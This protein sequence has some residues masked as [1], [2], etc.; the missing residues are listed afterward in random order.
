MTPPASAKAWAIQLTKMLAQVLGTDRFP[1]DVESLALDYSRQRFPDPITLVKGASLDGFEGALYRGKGAKAMW[2]IVYNASLPV[3]GR[4]RFVL[5]HEFGHYL[6]HRQELDQFF[7]TQRDVTQWDPKDAARETDANQFAS[8][9]LMPLDDFRRQ[10]AGQKIS[11]DLLGHCA[12]RYGVSLTATILKWLEFT[13][14]R[15]V[16]VAAREGFILWAKSS[17]PA[18]K[19]GAYIRTRGLVVP[20]PDGSVAAGAFG[21]TE[22]R[23]AVELSAGV[24][25]PNEPT[26]E[27]AIISDR[28][29]MT[30]SLLTLPTDHAVAEW[31]EEVE[32]DVYDRFTR[33]TR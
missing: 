15:A 12:N 32:E 23:A 18:F 31:E 2:S 7:C 9:L 21:A 16:L 24:W 19:S 28:F 26:T 5:A 6:R 14:Q 29:D 13:D 8:Y 20:V 22:W 11:L 27:M 4:I 33:P 10:I 25:F 17:E 3:P 30:I 1:V